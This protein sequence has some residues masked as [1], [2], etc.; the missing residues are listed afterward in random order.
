[1]EGE[2]QK[3]GEKRK[4]GEVEGDEGKGSWEEE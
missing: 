1:M 2:E 3:E 4:M